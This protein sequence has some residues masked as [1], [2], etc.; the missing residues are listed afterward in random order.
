MAKLQGWED[1]ESGL[2]THLMQHVAHL[3]NSQFAVCKDDM[4][5]PAALPPPQD[6]DGDGDDE[7]DACMHLLA[8]R[9]WFMLLCS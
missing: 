6:A 8:V 4:A 9:S 3:L 5:A 1:T 2:S 7:I